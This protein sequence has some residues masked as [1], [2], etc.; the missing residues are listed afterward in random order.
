MVESCLNAFIGYCEPYPPSPDWQQ[1]ADSGGVV[2]CPADAE[3][4]VAH[5][6]A[7][8]PAEVLHTAGLLEPH[9]DG[10]ELAAALQDGDWLLPHWDP[11]LG[12]VCGL[13][14]R[15]GLLTADGLSPISTLEQA[16]VRELR[17]EPRPRLF[18][19][20]SPEDLRALRSVG[21]VAVPAEDV[22]AQSANDLDA[23]CE[24]LHWPRSEGRL[25]ELDA[26]GQALLASVDDVDQN[27]DKRFD[28]FFAETVDEEPDT[29][30]EDL[31]TEVQPAIEHASGTE[32]CHE[33]IAPVSLGTCGIADE[34]Q[35]DSLLNN[36]DDTA[37]DSHSYS[38]S[39]LDAYATPALEVIL[40]AS[41]AAKLDSSVPVGLPKVLNYLRQIQRAMRK[42]LTNVSFWSL[43]G[44]T[45]D[46]LRFA[47]ELGDRAAVTSI[48]EDSLLDTR[49][50]VDGFDPEPSDPPSYVEAL[51]EFE[52][53]YTQSPN[54]LRRQRGIANLQ[55]AYGRSVLAP[56]AANC[57]SDPVEQIQ[58]GMVMQLASLS[59]QQYC[60][61]R[62]AMTLSP[63]G[64][65]S[66]KT[67]SQ[68]LATGDRILRLVKLMESSR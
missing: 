27:F 29:R 30:E 4:I 39:A 31:E 2:R 59:V 1:L 50:S 47:L 46:R 44:Q 43:D 63:L 68:Y 32:A 6:E 40:V 15:G 56:L 57:S 45:L 9:E 20:F 48:L 33:A 64:E 51:A 14:T 12:E 67:F 13:S 24:L 54:T 58:H 55:T 35:G 49:W 17:F 60:T 11:E 19:V 66:P 61:C 16:V 21:F 7:F 18:L 10:Y 53:I 65:L 22:H 28:D 26:Q 62:T 8:F 34:G 23:I 5:L 42:E 41:S 25:D 36:E 52:Q 3:A 38:L 37:G